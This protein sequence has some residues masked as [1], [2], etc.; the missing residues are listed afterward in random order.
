MFVINT[1]CTLPAEQIVHK[2]K[3]AL[4]T[5]VSG[6]NISSQM[7]TPFT[8]T[9]FSFI[10]DCLPQP[11]LHFN[12]PLLQFADITDPLLSTA[13][14]FSKFY[15]HRI[16]TWAV[17]V[18]SYLARW[19][20]RSHMQYA[21]EIGSNCDFQVS[22]GSV[23]AQL[24]WGGRP[25]NYYTQSFLGNLSVKKMKIELHLLKLWS[26]VK[27]IVFETQCRMQLYNVYYHS[28]RFMQSATFLAYPSGY[29]YCL[30]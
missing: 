27:C 1:C 10:N 14:L 18:A 15:N 24:R 13:R 17:K 23:A 20:M 16:Q 4:K 28:D 12:H 22:Q 29:V 3:Q 26:K 9:S 25:C 2:F 30:R 8:G 11:T 21:M 5:S 19:I 7:F 6:T